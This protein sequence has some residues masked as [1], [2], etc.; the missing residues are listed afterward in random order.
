M[1]L[2]SGRELAR[3]I[4][5]TLQSSG[6]VAYWVGGCVRDELLGLLPTD[7]DVATSAVP[8]EILGLFPDA[9]LIGASFGV[10]QVRADIATWSWIIGFG[11]LLIAVRVRGL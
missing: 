5:V 1:A 3:R 11:L 2:E 8:E 4:A 9:E 7:F 10:V 6:Y